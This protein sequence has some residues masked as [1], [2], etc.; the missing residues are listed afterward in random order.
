MRKSRFA[1]V[2][3][4]ARPVIVTEIKGK[5]GGKSHMRNSTPFVLCFAHPRTGKSMPDLETAV[6]SKNPGNAL[7]KIMFIEMLS[8]S[9]TITK[10]LMRVYRSAQPY[11]P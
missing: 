11:V 9:D 7:I 4:S 10:I 5:I 8:M 2:V 6:K 3:S 1:N